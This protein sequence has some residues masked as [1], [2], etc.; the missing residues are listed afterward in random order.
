MLIGLNL[1]VLCCEMGSLQKTQLLFWTLIENFRMMCLNCGMP[2]KFVGMIHVK[3]S[4][5]F[6]LLF[7]VM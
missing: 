1:V 3:L 4:S 6:R 2:H 7:S 5:L